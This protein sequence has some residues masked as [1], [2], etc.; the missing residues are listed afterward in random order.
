ML[1]INF[2]M[3]TVLKIIELFGIALVGLVIIITIPSFSGKRNDFV[4]NN[5]ELCGEDGSECFSSWGVHAALLLILWWYQLIHNN[6]L[7]NVRLEASKQSVFT[8]SCCWT[9]FN[10]LICKMGHGEQKNGCQYVC[11]DRCFTV[12]SVVKFL[13]VAIYTVVAFL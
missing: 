10:Y 5:P 12:Q 4:E 2:F 6:L 11:R 3:V 1:E 9:G 13:V 8:H 7:N